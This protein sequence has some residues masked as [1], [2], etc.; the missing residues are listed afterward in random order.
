MSQQFSTQWGGRTLTIEVGKFA[1]QANGSC[2]V[3]YGDT[4]VMG[5]ATMS[6]N[7]RDGIDWF[8]LSVDYDEKLYA[9]GII[10]GSRFIKREGRPSDEAILTGRMVDR[11]IRPLFNDLMRNDIQVVTTTLSFDGENDHEALCVIAA[12]CA[13]AISDIP[14]NGPVAGI[15]IGQIEG[16]WVIN[17]TVEVQLKSVLNLLITGSVENV[18]QIEADAQQVAEETFIEAMDFARKHLKEPIALIE[19]VRAAAGKEKRVLIIDAPTVDAAGDAEITDTAILDLTRA[20]IAKHA[21]EVFYDAPK[22][23]KAE[24]MAAFGKMKELLDTYFTRENISKDRRKIAFTKL[25]AIVE[26][27]ITEEVIERGRRVDGRGLRE[28]RPLN[29]EV[30]VLPRTHGTGFFQR[31]ETHVLSVVT[32]GSPGDEQILQ[33]LEG[34]SKKRYMHHYNFPAYSVGETGPNRGPGRREIGHGALAEKAL[35]PVLPPKETFPYTIRVVSEVM[36]SNGSSSMASTCGSTLA[37]MDAGVPLSAPVA[38]IAM[39]LAS[40][41]A[42]KYVIL[43]DLQDLEDGPGGM[44]FKIAGTRLGITAIQMDTK[45]PNGL[46]AQIIRE[47]FAQ[48]KEARMQVLDVMAKAIAHPRSDISQY[49]PKIVTFMIPVDKIREVI[50]PGGKVINEIID[51]CGVKIDIEQTGQVSVTAVAGAKL[52]EAVDWIKNIVRVVAAG[53]IF[54]QATVTRV[55]DYGFFAEVLPKQEGLVHVSEISWQRVESPQD[56]F[57]VGDHVKV[58]VKE[59]DDQGRISLSIKRMTPPPADYVERPPRE[60]DDRAGGGDRRSGGGRPPHGGPGGG[61]G[62]F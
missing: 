26:E 23:A 61:R 8:P 22:R 21:T 33:S 45:T 62:R 55:E 32:L 28:I 43:T 53:E 46:N 13:L 15:R 2:T 5:T 47:T 17:P 60:R 41:A 30:A 54:E 38:G 14:F 56:L 37:L 1:P 42:G 10:K 25:K 36:S 58:M 44:D 11:G 52:E 4:V 3:R 35:V 29:S 31:G 16:E 57:K 51:K 40:N 19:E 27:F 24:R 9:A 7:R 39:G 59:I 50:G 34:E 18:T 6:E 20:F 12:S 49:A 48:A